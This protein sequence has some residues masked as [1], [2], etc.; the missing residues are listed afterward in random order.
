MRRIA[1]AALATL[2]LLALPAGAS[3]AVTTTNDPTVLAGALGN[4]GAVGTASFAEQPGTGTPYATGDSALAGFPTEGGTYAILTTGDASI[5]DTANTSTGSSNGLGSGPA[6]GFAGAPG[7]AF[8]TSV[9]QIPITVP[10]GATCMKLDYKFFSEEWPENVGFSV[11]DGFLVMLDTAGGTADPA[12]D[13][14]APSNFAFDGKGALISVN[15]ADQTADNAAGTTYDGAT[16]LLTASHS[17]SQGA[18]TLYLAIFDQGDQALDSAAFV[19]NLR[20]DAT[21]A[22]TCDGTPDRAAPSVAVT[23]PAGGSQTDANPVHSG[24]AGTATTDSQNVTVQVYSGNAVAGTPVEVLTAPRQADGSWSVSSNGLQPG[25]YTVQ[26][27]QTDTAG[28]L[29][30]SPSTTFTVVDTVAPVPT[31]DTPAPGDVSA[32]NTPTVSGTAGLDATDLPDITVDV[33]AGGTAGGDPVDEVHTTATNGDWSTSVGPLANGVYTVTARQSDQAANQGTS[34]PVTF[35]VDDQAPTVRI[36]AP[37][38]GSSTEDTTPAISGT[39]GDAPGDSTQV[40]VT[41]RSGGAL[42]QTLHAT[43]SG[44][45]WSVR[46]AA[47]DPGDYT[48][49]ASQDDSAGNAG[50]SPAVAFTITAQPTPTPTPTPTP[51]QQ[52]DANSTQSPQ[53]VLGQTVVAGA[54]GGGTVRIKGKDGRFHTLGANESIPLGSTVDATKGKVRLTSASGPAG[55]VQTADFY[56]GAFVVT[57]TGGSKPITQLALAGALACPTKGKASAAARR[58]KVRR[59]W[60]DG[61]GSFRTKGRRA[62][63]TVRGTKW[64]TE[65]RCDS[66]KIT[67]KRGVVLV[68]DFVKRK[69]VVVKKGHSYVARSKKKKK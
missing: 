57:Q 18:H 1:A 64:L 47:L 42:V 27:H 11:N 38:D 29:G 48:A 32:D 39:A 23:S 8:D 45:A 52:V 59:L 68:R 41:L 40:T 10:A 21:P 50:T 6:H 13:I 37:A 55:Q 49:V 63:A 20:F 30:A 9:L 67:V 26:A 12:G 34:D 56:Q 22:A 62:A 43:R 17:V 36:T 53:P 14:A 44:T 51:Q 2:G 69:N 65:D 16:A 5:A 4:A 19:D 31:V 15:T 54:V 35:T 3:A 58:K 25:T 61:H 28:N 24:T 66:T 46:P 7:N 33:Y 60:G